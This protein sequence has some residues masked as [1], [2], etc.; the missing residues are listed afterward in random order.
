MKNYL[1]PLLGLVFFA[2]GNDVEIATYKVIAAN[3][4]EERS[5]HIIEL[6]GENFGPKREFGYLLD[7]L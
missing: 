7:I 1:L 2:C 5:A 3:S 6:K 4:I